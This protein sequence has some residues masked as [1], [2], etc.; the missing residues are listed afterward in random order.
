MFRKLSDTQRA[1]HHIEPV[2]RAVVDQLRED[3]KTATASAKT[4]GGGKDAAQDW[5][6]LAA[7]AQGRVQG[8]EQVLDTVRRVAQHG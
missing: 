1:A 2:I 3:Q 6:E 7:R 5:R 4:A 8:A